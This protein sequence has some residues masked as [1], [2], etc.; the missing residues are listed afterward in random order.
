MQALSGPFWVGGGAQ[1]HNISFQR[2]SEF[3][4][5]FQALPFFLNSI[6]NSQPVWSSILAPICRYAR[7]K[8]REKA[9]I[10]L[11]AGAGG[12]PDE[13]GRLEESGALSGDV[14][15]GNKQG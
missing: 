8:E 15:R 2:S 10:T 3:H 6:L 4:R 13:R 11:N 14:E 1:M 9:A 7:K 12:L 5:V